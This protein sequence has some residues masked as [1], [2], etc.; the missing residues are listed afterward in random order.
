MTNSKKATVVIFFSILSSFCTQS[1]GYTDFS[2]GD[3]TVQL[4]GRLLVD[5]AWYNSYEDLLLGDGTIIRSA[6]L[7]A[8][9]QLCSICDYQ[10]SIDFERA[11]LVLTDLNMSFKISDNVKLSIGQFRP[12][13]SLETLTSRLNISFLERALPNIFVTPRRIGVGLEFFHQ[14][15]SQFSIYYGIGGFGESANS[16]VNPPSNQDYNFSTRIDLMHTVS[17]SCY[18]LMGLALSYTRTNTENIIQY[19]PRPESNVTNVRLVDTGDI[20]NAKS[21]TLYNYEFTWQLN[22][23]SMQGEYFYNLVSRFD[24]DT[25][26]FDGFYIT[27][28]YFLT[29]DFRPLMK[30]IAEHGR[31]KP[32]CRLGA[33]EVIARLSQINLN[34]D[35]IHG[36]RER[37]IT[38]GANWYLNER[39]RLMGNYIHPMTKQNNQSAST[40]IYTIRS[41]YDF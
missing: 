11:R 17:P 9:G 41:Q 14:L 29:N 39:I 33:V 37:N 26:H 22:R 3:E 1:S 28:G 27:T 18:W 13:I 5:A 30:K 23:L 24:L 6:R 25:A 31:V 16:P 4:Y 19:A 38:F 15:N 20:T 36:G 10:L 7:G 21:A 34:H 8:K 32:H 12:Y 40:N 35:E 2:S